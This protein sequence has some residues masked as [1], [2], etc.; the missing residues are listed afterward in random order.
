MWAPAWFVWAGTKVAPSRHARVS[1][2][3][4][5]FKVLVASYNIL[6]RIRYVQH[7]DSWWRF[8]GPPVNVP[9]WWFVGAS[10]LGILVVALVSARFV[11]EDRPARGSATSRG[12]GYNWI[13]YG[14]VWVAVV[15]LLVI[16]VA[17]IA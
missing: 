2:C 1:I 3:L 17:Q 12:M 14:P 11:L 15:A 7:G 8:E 5:A 10:A 16:P 13:W 9:V 4:A 6:S